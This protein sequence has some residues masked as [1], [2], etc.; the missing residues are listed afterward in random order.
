MRSNALKRSI[1]AARKHN[2]VN[3]CERLES[4]ILGERLRW[5]KSE[6]E[7]YAELQCDINEVVGLDPVKA[8]VN[9]CIVDI[10][11]ARELGE[12]FAMPHI[13]LHGASGTGKR[14]SARLIAQL[15]ALVNSKEAADE[16]LIPLDLHTYPKDSSSDALVKAIDTTIEGGT[17]KIFKVGDQVTVAVDYKNRKKYGNA[18]SGPLKPGVYGTVTRSE[19]ALHCIVQAQD[20]SDFV[21]KTSVLRALVDGSKSSL[22]ELNAL[23]DLLKSV[24]I[25]DGKAYYVRIGAGRSPKLP[26]DDEVLSKLAKKH[27]IAILGCENEDDANKFLARVPSFRR[28]APRVIGLDSLQARDVALISA[29][30]LERLGYTV[31]KAQ[32]AH[33]RSGRTRADTLVA[34]AEARTK[35]R[36]RIYLARRGGKFMQGIV[37]ANFLE[38]ILRETYDASTLRERNA[39]LAHE[40]CR[41]AIARKNVRISTQMMKATGTVPLRLVLTPEDFNAHMLSEGERILRRLDIEAELQK[42]KGWGKEIEEGSPRH[43]L[44]RMRRLLI[45][46]DGGQRRTMSWHVSITGDEGVGKTTLAR[47][48]TKLLRAYGI[49]VSD[50]A[51]ECTCSEMLAMNADELTSVFN[52][53]Q[54]GTLTIDGAHELIDGANARRI[55]A[56]IQSKEAP[57]V[58][59]IGSKDGMGK[60]MR[61]RSSLASL[62]DRSVHIKEHSF[63]GLASIAQSYAVCENHDFADSLEAKLQKHLK[64]TRPSGRLPGDARGAKK[65]VDQA[66][67][68]ARERGYAVVPKESGRRQ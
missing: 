32:A 42:L 65:L 63:F 45:Q 40:F 47:I 4:R 36:R 56:Q 29:A 33:D 62:F 28:H 22:V 3:V 39:H 49:N 27:S 37:D 50:A 54:G 52:A 10:A 14:T 35:S 16:D 44:A 67:A 66:I 38:H 23:D 30:N 43:F 53:A 41:R 46:S 21:Y 8:F 51:E 58:I 7:A 15:V 17:T 20:R 5:S 1:D 55:V 57:T 48:Y 11:G 68:N 25:E 31:D 9:E 19:G 24:N 12:E 2:F 34:A 61:S 6:L 18:A 26:A 64:D 59:L 60:L 13:I